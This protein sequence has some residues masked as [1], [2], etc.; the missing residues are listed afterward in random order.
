MPITI[1]NWGDNERSVWL[2]RVR[3]NCW[4]LA[5]WYLTIPVWVQCQRPWNQAWENL[6]RGKSPTFRSTGMQRINPV[7]I[8]WVRTSHVQLRSTTLRCTAAQRDR[9]RSCSQTFAICWSRTLC[10]ESVLLRGFRS[11]PSSLFVFLVETE[12]RPPPK[13]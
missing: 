1:M 10:G 8:R 2:W 4:V 5:Y 12:N 3:S 11:W 6:A 9:M 7:R 13:F